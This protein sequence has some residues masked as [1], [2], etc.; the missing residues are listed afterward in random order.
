MAGALALCLAPASAA[1]AAAQL[2]PVPTTT[3]MNALTFGWNTGSGNYTVQLST[4]ANFS[5]IAF[6]GS[7]LTPE[8]TT[9]QNLPQDSLYYFRVKNSADGTYSASNST[10]SVTLAAAPS[11]L[12]FQ[13][14]EGYFSAE[15]SVTAHVNIGWATNGNP[16]YTEYILEYTSHTDFGSYKYSLASVMPPWSVGGNLLANTTY[17]FRVKASNLANIETSSSTTVSTATL[18]VRLGSLS[19]AAYRTSATVS[20]T[21][22]VGGPRE[23]NSEG[24]LLLMS[25]SS[26]FTGTVHSS[27]TAQPALGSLTIEGLLTNTTYYYRAGAINSNYAANLSDRDSFTTLAST[28]SAFALVSRDIS[29]ASLS[30]EALISGA[31]G[32]ELR[33]SSDNFAGAA[34]II[35]SRTY[36]LPDNSLTV[37]GL[38]PNTTWYFRAGSLNSA[39]VLNPTLVI[40]T[41]TKSNPVHL[42]SQ[43]TPPIVPGKT[44]LSVHFSPLPLSPQGSACRGYLL[45]R[46]TRPFGS[47]SVITSSAAPPSNNGV[48][49]F[50]GLRPSTTYY[51]R[52]ATLNWDNTPALTDIG[53]T[54]TLAA[55][56]LQPVTLYAVWSASAAVTF[57]AVGS[58]GYVLQASA[59]ASF[60]AAITE[61]FTPDGAASSVTVNGLDPNTLYYFRAGPVFSGTTVYTLSTPDYD[62][63]LPPR[64]S[65]VAFSGVF[66]SSAAVTWTALPASPRNQTADGG[67]L[68]EAST[69]PSFIPVDFSSASSSILTSTLA[70]A[71]L[72]AN[73][74]YYL[75]LG[76]LALDGGANYTLLPSTPTRAARPVQAPYTALSTATI[77]VNW[78][79]GTNPPDTRYRVI[80]TTASDWQAPVGA[81]VVSSDTY[82]TYMSTAGLTPNTTHFFWVASYNRRS[83]AEGPY[84][85]SPMAT[86]A[87]VPANAPPSG[88]GQS[89][90]TVNW[91]NGDNPPP[92]STEY[93]AEI[94]TYSDFSSAVHSSTTRNTSAWFGGL[95]SN[96]SYYSRVSALNHTGV[97]TAYRDLDD[98]LTLP[99]TAQ[100][101]ARP[102]AFSAMLLDGFTL[103][104]LH[105][106]NQ[107]DTV[108]AVEVSTKAGFDPM[109]SSGTAYG[110]SFGFTG[111]LINSTYFAR[112]QAISR[113]AGGRSAFEFAGSTMTLFSS[114]RTAV[115]GEDMVVTLP[116]SYGDYSVTVPAGALGGSTKITIWPETVFPS[117]PGNAG[118]LIPTGLGME[119]T[120]FPPVAVLGALTLS[121][122][123]LESS[124]PAGTDERGLILALYDVSSGGWVP[125]P[126]APDTAANIVRAQTWHLSTFQVMV[127]QPSSGVAGVKIYPNPFRPSSVAGAVRFANLPY[128]AEVR[129]YTL[130]GEL[131]REFKTG[132][133]GTGTWDGKN[134]KGA[135]VASGV[136]LAFIKPPD[137][138]G[139]VFKLAVER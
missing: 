17:Q 18:A 133:D 61:G 132:H 103:N 91:G 126:S 100:V 81:A 134:E 102:Q 33:A 75:R 19:Y 65:G 106:N 104:W 5:A 105:G 6:S 60:A 38:E 43:V 118:T 112:V 127:S 35:S 51:L 108:Y 96:A 15:S 26:S 11:G 66:Y 79:A 30:W 28:I 46:S 87:F 78:T 80:S 84:A 23:T 124:L 121:V 1:P 95:L 8:T 116:T 67:Y 52:L 13:G 138:E 58:D 24:Y 39:G 31:A 117:A 88:V 42:N 113:G 129:I 12:F 22:M 2:N 44:S 40:S 55:D 130:L 128:D 7:V 41:I 94:S 50:D 47:G 115:Y 48:I 20:W 120:H 74:S 27:A 63:T 110:L 107:T 37:G 114:T 71:G 72:T 123:Y 93:T 92:P 97:G 136:Y 139:K 49:G 14:G 125:L 137:G 9:Y 21:P 62:Y 82:N 119:I 90:V 56:P 98:P 101:L 53:Y 85:F 29:E 83:I 131:V 111:L 16:E 99:A 34:A 68:L 45:Q 122:P 77:R 135:E 36:A 89:S 64:P 109:Y 70:I 59:Y 57:G 32:Y 86:L 3:T 76:T 25:S 10:M 4:A 73:T 54:A 69:S